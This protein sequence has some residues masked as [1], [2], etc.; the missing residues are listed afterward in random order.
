MT[1]NDPKPQP[2]EQLRNLN[3]HILR[4]LDAQERVPGSPNR[5]PWPNLV[6]A[7]RR[8]YERLEQAGFIARERTPKKKKAFAVLTDAGRQVLPAV[9]DYYVHLNAW[10][11]R[12]EAAEDR[13]IAMRAAAEQLA[14]ALKPF[15]AIAA[16]LHDSEPD[17]AHFHT[18]GPHRLLNRDIRRAAAALKAAGVNLGE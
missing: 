13:A 18:F 7:A 8:D 4:R 10:V 16:W 3:L 6:G 17:E 15:A 11:A 9:R 12:Q 5:I 2:I 1:S 14:E